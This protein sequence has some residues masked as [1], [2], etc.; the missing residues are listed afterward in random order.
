M[1]IKPASAFFQDFGNSCIPRFFE[2]ENTEKGGN[3]VSEYL[4]YG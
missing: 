2:G 1:L 4:N 3:F